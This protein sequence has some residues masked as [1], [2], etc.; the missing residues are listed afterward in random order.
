[1]PMPSDKIFLRTMIYS[2][3]AAITVGAC[4][5]I[6]S[7]R[8]AIERIGSLYFFGFLVGTVHVGACAVFLT[9][10]RIMVLSFAV[11]AAMLVGCLVLS[12]VV[13]PEDHAEL[14]KSP[15]LLIAR[16]AVYGLFAGFGSWRI[17]LV[18]HNLT[19]DMREGGAMFVEEKKEEI[20]DLDHPGRAAEEEEEPE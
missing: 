5:G 13:V 8:A 3:V 15:Y 9:R 19:Q 17:A 6:F 20:W 2:V 7:P 18:S 16:A 11:H 4:A 10:K 14:V 1:M 12:L